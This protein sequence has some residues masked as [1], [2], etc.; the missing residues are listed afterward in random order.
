MSYAGIPSLNLEFGDDLQLGSYH[1]AYDDFAWYKR[2]GD[3]GFLYGRATAQFNGSAVIGL[4]DAPILPVEFSATSD[5]VADELAKLKSL[6]VRL[7]GAV[8]DQ[9]RI[10]ALGA[11]RVLANPAHPLVP[12]AIADV[13]T[14]DFAPLDSAFAKIRSA[15]Q[16]FAK[17]K[18]VSATQSLDATQVTKIDRSLIAVE[19]SF[20]RQGGLPGRAFYQNELYSPGR[21]WDTVPMPAIGDAMLD[22]Q[23]KMA[24]AQV[25]L[26]TQTLLNLADAIDAASQLLEV[27]SAHP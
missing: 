6:Y 25:P 2:F 13:P 17:A 20:L 3:P 12:S 7:R 4:A 19:R 1:S 21:L 26:V 22:G 18:E 10:V 27:S 14:M 9:N 5:A 8:V 24:A 11:Y 16:R 23:W 15:S